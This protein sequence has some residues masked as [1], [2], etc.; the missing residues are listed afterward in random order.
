ML[1]NSSH[2]IE[3]IL[4]EEEAKKKR[5][6]I[7]KN[8]HYHGLGI[9]IF[10]D[11]IESLDRP[12]AVF[13]WQSNNINNYTNKDYIVLTKLIN[14]DNQRIIIPIFIETR[15]NYFD[16]STKEI[17]Q[18]NTN[19]IKSIYGRNKIFTYLNNYIKNGSLKKI[20]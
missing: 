20:K 9:K 7:N 2:V 1:M 11:A 14:N 17:T 4:T 12:T 6:Q 10:I 8:I 16:V 3:N 15:G 13:Q 5:L 19:K 18:I